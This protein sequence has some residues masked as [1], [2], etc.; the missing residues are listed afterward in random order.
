MCGT[1]VPAGTP[2][3]STCNK[4]CSHNKTQ[5]CRGDC[6][7]EVFKYACTGT[8]KPPSPGPPKPPSPPPPT[9]GPH[10]PGPSPP[11]PPEMGACTSVLDCNLNGDC[12]NSRCE[13][14]A[15][16]SESPDCAVMAFEAIEPGEQQP[17]YYNVSA[18]EATQSRTT[19]LG[20]W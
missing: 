1:A 18:G 20:E 5:N 9:P 19:R 10:P 13:C 17:G 4:M 8:P 16:W 14:D 7:I 11:P 3:A 6:A 12:I 15:A 2:I